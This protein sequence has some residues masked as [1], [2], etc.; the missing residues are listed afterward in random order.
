MEPLRNRLKPFDGEGL[1]SF[2]CRNAKANYYENLSSVL[3]GI[4]TA[5]HTTSLNYLND[6]QK[7]VEVVKTFTKNEVWFENID[8]LVQ[9]QFDKV[10]FGEKPSMFNQA[11][12]Y[13]K[14]H[15]RFCP[16]CIKENYYYRNLWDVSFVTV[17]IKHKTF[18]VENCDGCG[19]KIS[20][21]QFMRGYCNCGKFYTTVNEKK[22]VY[23]K[24]LQVQELIQDILLNKLEKII[25]SDS[26]SLTPREYFYF[27]QLFGL[28]ID[29]I[30]LDNFTKNIDSHSNRALNYS[31]KTKELRDIKMIN[32]IVISIHELITN[33][34]KALPELLRVLE[35]KVKNKS[36]ESYRKKYRKLL[37]VFK[38]RKGDIY[39]Q[40]YESCLK[41]GNRTDYQKKIKKSHYSTKEAYN[42]IGLAC[43]TFNKINFFGSIKIPRSNET[44]QYIEKEKIHQF[45]GD[46]TKQ[47]ELVT[48]I[49]DENFLRFNRVLHA[50]GQ[51]GIDTPF[52]ITLIKK[53]YFKNLYLLEAKPNL[54]GLYLNKLEVNALIDKFRKQQIGKDK[55]GYQKEVKQL[56][57]V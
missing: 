19:Q 8:C 30:K 42:I 12:F 54:R 3:N 33:P 48:R 46:V 11:I 4:G 15:A 53:G 16:S 24:V 6:N 45:L 35:T 36:N 10:I 41:N 44:V 5:I 43:D 51:Y 37:K 39:K 13:N 14:Y 34:H 25:I 56:L 47:C 40:I 1:Y 52:L 17:C 50:F 22:K 31:R 18:L 38:H 28:I 49:E 7:W 20:M 57:L 27:F 21:H 9:N 32:Q 29:N 2:L 55:T 23:P 26:V